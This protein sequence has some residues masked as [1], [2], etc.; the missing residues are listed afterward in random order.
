MDVREIDD[1]V[2]V[3]EGDDGDWPFKSNRKWVHEPVTVGGGNG[4]FGSLKD[5]QGTDFWSSPPVQP[6]DKQVGGDHY[7]RYPIQPYEYNQKNELR[8][9]EGNVIKYVTRH[10]NKYGK[11]DLLKAIHCIEL[12]IELEYK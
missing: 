4:N 11:E 1:R 9:L 3:R 7:K 5:P 8:Y 10:R 6:R 12:L 2:D